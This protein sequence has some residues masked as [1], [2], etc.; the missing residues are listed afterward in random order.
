LGQTVAGFRFEFAKDSFVCG[1]KEKMIFVKVGRV[2][3]PRNVCHI[4]EQI[5]GFDVAYEGIRVGEAEV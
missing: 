4:G 5:G 1:R 3:P 2:K